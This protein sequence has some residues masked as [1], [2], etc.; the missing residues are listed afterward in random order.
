MFHAGDL[1]SGI[2]LAVQSQ[3]AV[4]CFIYGKP[5]SSLENACIDVTDDAETSNAWE[6]VLSDEEI[7]AD[8]KEQTVAIKLKAGSQEAG[9][10]NSICPIN[11]TPAI[12]VIR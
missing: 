2:A 9:F 10:L 11:S 12:I 7:S 3:K 5:S 8:L 4:L 6:G 1:Q